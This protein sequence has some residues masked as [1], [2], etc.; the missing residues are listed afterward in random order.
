MSS[1]KK[2]EIAYSIIHTIVS[3]YIN[4]SLDTE[5]AIKK[6]TNHFIKELNSKS[7]FNRIL[8]IETDI[9]KYRFDMKLMD[10]TDEDSCKVG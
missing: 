2:A 1:N 8:N 7:Y 9:D 10:I 3:D 6:I 4:Q 5:S